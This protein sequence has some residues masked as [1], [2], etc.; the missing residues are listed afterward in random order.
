VESIRHELELIADQKV[1]APPEVVIWFEQQLD[2]ELAK[3]V[4]SSEGRTA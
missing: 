4:A 2:A 3:L 1:S